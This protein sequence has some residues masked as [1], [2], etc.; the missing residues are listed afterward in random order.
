MTNQQ[1]NTLLDN[2]RTCGEWDKAVTVLAENVRKEQQRQSKWQIL[3]LA[4]AIATAGVLATATVT[5]LI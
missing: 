1:I 3:C 4:G 2:A 5:A